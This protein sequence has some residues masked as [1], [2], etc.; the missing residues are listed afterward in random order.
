MTK[1]KKEYEIL[2]LSK[3]DERIK[4]CEN[5]II[6]N[7]VSALAWISLSA[8]GILSLAVASTKEENIFKLIGGGILVFSLSIPG[9]ISSINIHNIKKEMNNNISKTLK[10]KWKFI[11]LFTVEII[12][13]M[14]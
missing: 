4:D 5:R 8:I 6:D 13:N 2:E 9:I 11:F 12:I 14:I 7:V 3:F 1:N 10:N